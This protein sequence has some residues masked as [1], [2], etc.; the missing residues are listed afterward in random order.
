MKAVKMW[1]KFFFSFFF[2][3]P[4]VFVPFLLWPA[5]TRERGGEKRAARRTILGA[6]VQ[7]CNESKRWNR[8]TNFPRFHLRATVQ[9][10]GWGRWRAAARPVTT[11]G[12]NCR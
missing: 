6:N 12:G 2:F 11:G 3:F 7:V 1:E 8:H 10:D 9:R 5:T 4:R